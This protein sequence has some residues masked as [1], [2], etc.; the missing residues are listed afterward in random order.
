M[1][2][3]M[4]HTTHKRVIDS[5]NLFQKKHPDFIITKFNNGTYIL[6]N[7]GICLTFLASL[8]KKYP[9]TTDIYVAEPI[10]LHQMPNLCLKGA[11][12]LIENP[13]GRNIRYVP[14]H[15]NITKE[16][17]EKCRMKI[18]LISSE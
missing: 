7:N 13:K 1:T 18:S 4:L 12:W 2:W 6:K 3:L 9:N 16:E 8:V 15:L 11:E 17:L 14:K 5:V 10:T